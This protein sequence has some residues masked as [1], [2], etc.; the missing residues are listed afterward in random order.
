MKSTAVV[1]YELWNNTYAYQQ[2]DLTDIDELRDLLLEYGTKETKEGINYYSSSQFGILNVPESILTYDPQMSD[3]TLG[4]DDTFK[5]DDVWGVCQSNKTM[6]DGI[7]TINDFDEDAL[8][9]AGAA[10]IAAGGSLLLVFILIPIISCFCI[11]LCI[12]YCQ[13]CCCFS[14]PEPE[15]V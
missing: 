11:L 9:A 15:I 6:C 3:N 14:K 8:R 12:C 4:A 2:N 5:F 10:A 1:G 7:R 13:K